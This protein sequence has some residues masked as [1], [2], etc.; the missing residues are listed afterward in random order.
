MA[1]L[2]SFKESLIEDLKDI[3]YA[4]EYLSVAL[5]QYDQ[6]KDAAAF[7]V[8]LKD[9]AEAQGGLTRLARKTNLNRENLYKVLSARGNPRLDTIGSLLNGLGFRLAVQPIAKGLV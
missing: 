4:R 7:L 9:V 1:R 3:E 5:E 6:D 8:A 2:T